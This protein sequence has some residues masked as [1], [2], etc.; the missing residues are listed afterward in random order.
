LNFYPKKIPIEIFISGFEKR[1]RRKGRVWDFIQ[2]A[3]PS[4]NQI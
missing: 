2:R 1:T 3:I 4:E